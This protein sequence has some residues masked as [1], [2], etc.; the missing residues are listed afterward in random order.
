MQC[1]WPFALQ[2]VSLDSVDSVDSVLW[3]KCNINCS[4]SFCT[5]AANLL[6]VS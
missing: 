5:E 4:S 2:I 1:A 6:D 3:L